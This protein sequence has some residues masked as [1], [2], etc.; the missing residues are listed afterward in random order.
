MNKV[1]R[2]VG[3]IFL[4]LGT[5]LYIIT[6]FQT[7]ALSTSKMG[8]SFFPRVVAIIMIVCS[9]GLIIQT[10]IAMKYNHETE[11]KPEVNWQKEKKVA[12]VFAMLIVYA[13]CIEPVGFLISSI[14]F[15]V[16]LLYVLNTRKWWYYAI[17]IALVGV[18]YYVFSKLLYIHLP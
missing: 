17:Y 15:G 11:E 5:V 10:T 12:F 7:K 4:F 16:A 3:I 6:P 14:V 8:P 18:V 1:N 9:I 13:L 2:V